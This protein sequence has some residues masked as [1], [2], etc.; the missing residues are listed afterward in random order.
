MIYAS[1]KELKKGERVNARVSFISQPYYVSNVFVKGVRPKKYR[2]FPARIEQDIVTGYDESYEPVDGDVMAIREEVYNAG[3]SKM[4]FHRVKIDKEFYKNHSKKFTIE[5]YFEKPVTVFAYDK[6]VKAN[7][8][9]AS[10]AIRFTDVSP[11]KIKDMLNVLD[12]DTEAKRKEDGNLAY[13]YED[14]LFK[15]LIGRFVS[16]KTNP[17]TK[18]LGN[19][20]ITYAEFTFKEGKEFEINED[21]DFLNSIPENAPVPKPDIVVSKKDIKQ[22]EEDILIEN[23]PF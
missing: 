18:D 6:E 8:E 10:H 2:K 4:E 3:T 7:V 1:Q 5:L 17:V 23:L 21:E 12:L 22:R 15:S 11:S 13:D 20:P 9:K 16:F 19:W 14:E